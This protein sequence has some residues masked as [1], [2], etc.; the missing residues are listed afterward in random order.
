METSGKVFIVSFMEVYVEADWPASSIMMRLYFSTCGVDPV[1]VI[2][3][4]SKAGSLVLSEVSI[5]IR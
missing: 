1:Q 4:Q 5:K 3:I 2:I